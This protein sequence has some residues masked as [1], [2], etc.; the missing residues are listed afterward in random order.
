LLLDNYERN[1][2]AKSSGEIL[3]ISVIQRYSLR[4][5]SFIY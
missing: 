5:T 2:S 3:P 4:K 1:E